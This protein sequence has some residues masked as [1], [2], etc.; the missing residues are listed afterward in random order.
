MLG[1][2]GCNELSPEILECMEKFFVHERTIMI[3]QSYSNF[4]GKH[5]NFKVYNYMNFR[6]HSFT[7][8][9]AICKGKTTGLL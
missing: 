5:M 8:N 6:T 3:P 4:V 1:S 2:F 7:T 9:V